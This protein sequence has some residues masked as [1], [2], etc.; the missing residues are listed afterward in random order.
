LRGALRHCEQLSE[1]YPE[2]EEFLPLIAVLRF[3][4]G[5]G[6]WKLACERIIESTT[7]SAES[8]ALAASLLDGSFGRKKDGP[9]AA[10]EPDDGTRRDACDL[11]FDFMAHGG[12]MR[13]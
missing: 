4:G 11:P 6:A 13:A 8:R 5:D 7:S 9:A 1:Q 3:A 12:F 2:S 10:I